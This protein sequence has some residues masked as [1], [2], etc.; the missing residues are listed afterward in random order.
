M[1]QRGVARVY[2]LNSGKKEN[3][4]EFY[5]SLQTSVKQSRSALIRSHRL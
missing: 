4:R 2:G 5:A 1:L 3:I